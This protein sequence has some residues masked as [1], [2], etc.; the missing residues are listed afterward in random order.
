MDINGFL[1][2]GTQQGLYKFEGNEVVKFGGSSDKGGKL[3]SSDIRGIAEQKN[4]KIVIATFGQGI[5]EFLPEASDFKPIKSERAL[6]LQD[7]HQILDDYFIAVSKSGIKTIN[8]SYGNKNDWLTHQLSNANI[9][10]VV[11]SIR[12]DSQ[13]TLLATE[14]SLLLVSTISNTISKHSLILSEEDVTAIALSD[15]SELFIS[16]SKSRLYRFGTTDYKLQTSLDLS[17]YNVSNISDLLHLND[18]LWI[19]TDDGVFLASRDLKIKEHLNQSNSQLSNNHITRLFYDGKILFV[20]SFN[21][22]DQILPSTITSFNRLNSNVDN[23]VL[24]FAMSSDKR[25][26]VGTYNGVYIYDEKSGQ[27]DHIVNFVDND[28]PD[29]RV[30]TLAIHGDELWIG[31]AKDG[32]HKLDILSGRIQSFSDSNDA[33]LEVTKILSTSKGRVYISTYKNGV[34][35]VQENELIQVPSDG[36]NSF[37][38]LFESQ[39]GRIF[40]TTER[41]LFMLNLPEKKFE[42]IDLDFG[43]HRE[44]PILLSM[45]ESKE[46][47]L[48]LGTKSHGI[49]LLEEA[50]GVGETVQVKHFSDDRVLKSSTIYGM[51]RDA[52]SNIWCSTQN[53]I[54][55]IS[56]DG[57]I[58]FRLTKLDGLQGNDFNYGAYFLDDAGYM[59]F[60]GVNGYSRL[61]SDQRR[62]STVSSPILINKIRLSHSK[63]LR[64]GEISRLETLELSHS[65]R[66]F[67]LVINL[68]D[69]QNPRANQYT[70]ILEGLDRDW[71]EA[72]TNNVVAYTNL[73][74]G[75]YIFR[76]RGANAAGVWS[77]NEVRLRIVVL[78]PWWRTWW[79]FGTYGVLAVFI[80]WM[81]MRTYRSHLLKEEALRIAQE[82]HDAA[83][84]AQDDLQESQEYQDELVSAVSQHNLATLDLISKCLEDIECNDSSQVKIL[85][86]IKALELLEKCYFFQDGE[87]VADMHSYVDGLTNYLLTQTTVDPATITTINRVT[88]ETLAAHVASP[89]AVILYELLHNAMA[90]AFGPASSA[91]FIEISLNIVREPAEDPILDLIVADDGVGDRSA[92]GD[93]RSG[94]GLEVVG[95]LAASLGA[96]YN[97]RTNNGNGY[98]AQLRLTLPGH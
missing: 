93:S 66:S 73:D 95:S 70:H 5:Y 42:Q 43:M 1:W 38:H 63:Q 23:D 64:F 82:M 21:G 76:A 29:S 2:I 51:V 7:L 19:A 18:E 45:A 15:S 46:G 48:L 31:L 79:A 54:F 91:N 52:E 96:R 77:D 34:Y 28:L 62:P 90:H 61:N 74:P 92:V 97:T 11:D 20:G 60:G 53:G 83:D 8:L 71:T 9:V 85:G 98:T 30:T 86:H 49:Y 32:V 65:D 59:Y 4:G 26:W 37:N 50:P 3:K 55:K 14:D 78:P 81:M 89:L 75:S 10:D 80:L 22:L 69:Y 40:A 17:N 39:K 44:N 16:T 94:S 12:I 13:K 84:R 27:H 24:A 6:E 25:L 36:E 56:R 33:D 68:L 67:A 87:L 35:K 47:Q 41:K 72:S 57:Q 88:R 58:I